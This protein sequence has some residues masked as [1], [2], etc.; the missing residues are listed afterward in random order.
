[1]N[2]R[3]IPESNGRPI[4]VRALV[5]GDPYFSVDDF[6]PAMAGVGSL[7]TFDY[8]QID[9]TSVPAPRTDSERRLREYAGDP[10]LMAIAV[11]NHDALVVHGAPVSAETLDCP[12]L[13]IVCCVRGGPVN[14]D[15]QAATE[16]GVLVCTAP[17]KNAVAVAELTIAFVLMTMRSVAASA[18]EF[19]QLSELG[20]VFDGRR[21]LGFEA[22][23]TTIG[24]VGYGRVGRQVAR[25]AL[26]LG[27]GVI[28]HDP[29]VSADGGAVEMVTLDAL[30]ARSDV[31]SLHARGGADGP[32]MGEAQFQAM[33]KGVCFVNTAREQLVD[34][35]ALARA[36]DSGRIRAAAMDVIEPGP[37]PSRNPL[38]DRPNVFVTPHIGGATRETLRRGAQMAAD[39]IR[40]YRD[41]RPLPYLAN[42]PV[43]TRQSVPR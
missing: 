33:R 36:L 29:F 2:G 11:P 27:F 32:L 4:R 31:V 3:P 6:K 39:A 26:A 37:G 12:D 15:L 23:G 13:R 42:A 34:E 41:G 38:V 9:S 16:R 25:R 24:L 35:A 22:E 30:L 10:A 8:L 1:V 28:A 19:A 18:R 40:A 14:V 7:V 21:H 20:S 5:V 43:T 17:G